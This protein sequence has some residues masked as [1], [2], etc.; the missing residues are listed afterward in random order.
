MD[1]LTFISN[2]V[3]ALAW[4]LAAVAAL[5]LLRRPIMDLLPSIKKLKIS[6]FEA[7]FSKELS[8]VREKAGSNGEAIEDQTMRTRLDELTDLVEIGPNAAVL[9]AFQEVEN[10]AKY[11]LDSI[12]QTI[13]YSIGS[14]YKVMG[15]ILNEAGLFDNKNLK[16]FDELRILR[17][18]VAHADGYEISRDQSLEY[19]KLAMQ[20]AGKMVARKPRPPVRKAG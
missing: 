4:P 9:S 14:P 12:G 6:E 11:L 2:L 13:D 1:R 8:K 20:L 15:R 5:M 19:V 18:K 16:V 3:D 10:A 17:N 7:E